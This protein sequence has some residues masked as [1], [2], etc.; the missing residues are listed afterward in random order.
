MKDEA[1]GV[2]ISGST[3]ALEPV[4]DLAV[5]KVLDQTLDGKKYDAYDIRL[6]GKAGGFVQPNGTVAVT[7]PVKADAEVETIYYITPE[8]RLEA[9][10]FTQK[11]GKVTFNTTHFSV[12]AVVYKGAVAAANPT[13]PTSPVT[14]AT[15]TTPSTPPA[16]AS[17]EPGR[18]TPAG[19]KPVAK[20]EAV[21][22]A[23]ANQLPATGTSD[24]NTSLFVASL[25]LALGTLFY[26][27]GK[28]KA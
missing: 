21:N 22:G 10:A 15:P 8:K 18:T 4:K 23:V 27:K 14:P 2:M 3:T 6:G 9:L 11:D 24:A 1:T 13:T 7:V 5:Q 25:A 28:E 17:G 20:P 16:V 19:E 12:Y 26:K